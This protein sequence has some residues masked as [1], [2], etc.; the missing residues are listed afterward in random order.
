MTLQLTG[1]K[2]TK[3]KYHDFPGAVREQMPILRGAGYY[4]CSVADVVERRLHAPKE[5]VSCWRFSRFHTI[6]ACISDEEG[7]AVISLD[8]PSLLSLDGESEIYDDALVPSE[9]QLYSEK[10]RPYSSLFLTPEQVKMVEGK[11]YFLEGSVWRPANEIV[12]MIYEGTGTFPGLFRGKIDIQEYL[13]LVSGASYDPE[14]VMS[15]DLFMRFYFNFIRKDGK[16]TI[17]SVVVNRTDPNSTVYGHN[18]L[19]YGDG[20]LA[21]VASEAP[22]IE[23]RISSGSREGVKLSP[24]RRNAVEEQQNKEPPKPWH[25]RIYDWVRRR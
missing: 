18:N 19:D 11:G 22:F 6:D 8:S 14:F 5:V 16:P 25:Q 4:P 23:S 2:E 17:R 15:S 7:G 21:G 3:G 1:K 20:R 10:N 13:W 24:Y 12:K 9:E